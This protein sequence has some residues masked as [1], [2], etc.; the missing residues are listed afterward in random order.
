MDSRIPRPRHIVIIGGGIIG[1]TT[2]YY[3]TR[4]P[5]FNPS[6]HHITLVE[7]TSSIASA[8]SGKAGGLLG[9][10]AYP[11]CLSQLSYRLHAELA[12]EHDGAARWGYRQLNCGQLVATVR[13]KDSK[14]KAKT[15][16]KHTSGKAKRANSGGN[17][18]TP[19][20]E[21][22]DVNASQPQDNNMPNLQQSE[23][24]AQSPEDGK[25][26]QRL[27]KQD[28]A[29]AALVRQSV[30]PA[31]LDWIDSELVEKYGEMGLPGYTST[32]QVHPYQFTNSIADLARAA[33]V[34]IRL[35]AKV[36]KI[37]MRPGSVQSVEYIDRVASQPRS[38]LGVTDVVVAAGPWTSTLLPQTKVDGLRA[39]SVVF[40]ADVS[41]FAVFTNIS[42]PSTWIPSHRRRR[43]HKGRVDP[44][45]YARP[46]GEVYACGELDPSTPLPESADLVQ[47]DEAQCDDI[48][49][50]IGT[51]STKL[52]N[53]PI[54][55]KQACYMPQHIRAGKEGS[56]LVGGTAVEGL[57]VAAGHTCWG[58][59]NGPATGL[60]MSE[61]ILEGRAKSADIDELDPKAF[62]I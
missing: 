11:V 31:N 43:I 56:P 45:C 59:Q 17:I 58:I 46:A 29:A 51:V 28:E 60:L 33:G 10:W 5:F 9:L 49:S 22:Q 14:M 30:L 37:G 21:S 4:H 36:T 44:E 42:L 23:D 53:S 32:A 52:R 2:A 1:V 50:Y 27:P 55:A 62:G 12:A 38:I 34:D 6:I 61:F 7:A 48:A 26:W 54:I 40:Q 35:N 20:R 16:N 18:S 19:A 25:D 13:G 3:L 24:H 15:A 47:V 57:W 39:H 41:P 8:A